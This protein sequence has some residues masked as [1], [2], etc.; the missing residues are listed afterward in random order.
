MDLLISYAY[1][2][3]ER[4]KEGVSLLDFGA[5]TLTRRNYSTV[6]DMTYY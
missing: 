2:M 5:Y 1:A 4:F 3:A 6:V